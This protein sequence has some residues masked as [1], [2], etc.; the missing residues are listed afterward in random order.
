MVSIKDRIKRLEK[1]AEKRGPVY[2]YVVFQREDETIEAARER[3][4]GALLERPQ[5]LLY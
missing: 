2:P 5:K 1:R 3:T 4:L